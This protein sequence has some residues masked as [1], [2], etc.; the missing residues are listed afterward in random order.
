MSIKAIMKTK[1]VMLK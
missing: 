1:A